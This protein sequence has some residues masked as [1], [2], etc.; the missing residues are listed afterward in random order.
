MSVDLQRPGVKRLCVDIRKHEGRLLFSVSW[1]DITRPYPGQFIEVSVL[2]EDGA[3]N[4]LV[5]VMKRV[6]EALPCKDQS[7]ADWALN[8]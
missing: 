1:L 6:D 5:D 2:L 8:G 7:P 4:K 3:G